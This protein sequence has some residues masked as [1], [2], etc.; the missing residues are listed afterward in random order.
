MQTAERLGW[1]GLWAERQ[2]QAR[3]AGARFAAERLRD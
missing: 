2:E 1:T 3:A